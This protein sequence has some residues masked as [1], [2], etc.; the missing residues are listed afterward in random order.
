MPE[1]KNSRYTV[2]R[3]FDPAT[4]KHTVDSLESLLAQLPDEMWVPVATVE[5][6]DFRD[7]ILSV[8]GEVEGD[9]VAT[10]AT[11]WEAN[12][13]AVVVDRRPVVSL[14]SKAEPVQTTLA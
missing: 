13:D 12:R 5:A 10:P 7:A 8:A 14:R 4:L 1:I 2:L 3:R 9:Y 11:R 6:H